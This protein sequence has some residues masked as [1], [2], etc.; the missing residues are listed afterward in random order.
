MK[1]IESLSRM[2]MTYNA[3]KGLSHV[4]SQEDLFGS[5]DAHP[6]TWSDEDIEELVEERISLGD[7]K[8]DFGSIRH[9]YETEMMTPFQS[10]FFGD[11]AT[12]FLMQVRTAGAHA[13]CV[14]AAC[15]EGLM[16]G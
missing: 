5:V 3:R 8:P 15:V 4:G 11:L 16:H 14:G 6:Y 1:E 10:L 9:A 7:Q 13:S 2:V 12:L